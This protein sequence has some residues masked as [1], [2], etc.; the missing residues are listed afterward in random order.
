M[1]AVTVPTPISSAAA[2][3]TVVT[4]GSAHTEAWRRRLTDAP[5]MRPGA[6]LDLSPGDA[7]VVAVAHPDDETLA[8]GATLARLARDGVAVHVLVMTA[9]EAA[10]D[11]L[12]LHL[13][14]VAQRRRDEAATAARVLG[15][16]SLSVLDLPDGGLAP[17]DA[18]MRQAVAAA[19]VGHGAGAVAT[20]WRHDPHPD[21]Q[22]VSR[23]AVA[24]AGTAGVGVAEFA[25]W[26]THWTEPS[27]VGDEVVLVDSGEQASLRKQEALACYVSQNEPLRDDVDPVVPAD[28]RG[29]P[30]EYVVRPS[31]PPLPPPA[32]PDFD[33]M[34]T[35]DDDPWEVASS[36]Y[37][38]RKLE[39][40]LATLPREHY[41]RAWEPGCGPGLVSTR[42]AD[43]VGELVASDSSTAAIGLARRR[44]GVPAHVRFVRS[45]LPEV[46]LEG[47]VDLLL[48]AEFL[49]YVPDLPGALDALWSATAPG[50]QVVFLHWAHRPH[51]AHRSG[52]EMHA[53]IYLDSQRRDAVKIVSHTDQDFLLD[54]YEV[55]G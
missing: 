25:L 22:A 15:A 27:E 13:D 21:H 17:C 43:R 28:V 37:E 48:V 33:A 6:L 24:A 35:A 23:A 51:D 41:D 20:L 39:V 1:D 19:V 30:H 14:D 40:L 7:V 55:T 38:R 46:P 47:T 12:G 31:T 53:R 36:W 10:L 11:H 44:L 50:T 9:G 16:A 52:P 8:M 2:G 54:V 49:Y 29:W 34:Y 32:W 18:E 26:T 45:Q 42:L 4:P 3:R 5:V